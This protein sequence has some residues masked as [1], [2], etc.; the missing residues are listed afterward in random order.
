MLRFLSILRL[1]RF[2]TA[3]LFAVLVLAT[4]APGDDGGSDIA[5]LTTTDSGEPDPTVAPETEPDPT[6]ESSGDATDATPETPTSPNP[7]PA[8]ESDAEATET[9]TEPAP[10]P[11]PNDLPDVTV[12]DVYT[13]DEVGLASFA[14]TDKPIVVWFWAP[15]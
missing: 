4:C 11:G 2:V 9:A 7:A 5:S 13:G 3:T 6:I 14:P 12:V 8:A 15:H 1:L 10:T